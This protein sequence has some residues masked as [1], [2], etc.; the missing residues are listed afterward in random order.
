MSIYR[1]YRQSLAHGATLDIAVR[2]PDGFADGYFA[3]WVPTS[4]LRTY[5]DVLIDTLDAQWV[6]A[7]DT[8][9]IRLRAADT[10]GWPQGPAQFDVRLTSPAGV[11]LQTTPAT[12]SITKGVTRL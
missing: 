6:D 10:S 1:P 4:Q 7:A 12:L 9:Y 5:A 3:G 8:R 11:R 2:I